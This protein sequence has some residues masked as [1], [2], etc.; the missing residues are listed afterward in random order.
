MLSDLDEEWSWAT[1]KLAVVGDDIEVW[2]IVG[3]VMKRKATRS[4]VARSNLRLEK[5]PEV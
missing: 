3:A 5:T 2:K 4:Q 1:R